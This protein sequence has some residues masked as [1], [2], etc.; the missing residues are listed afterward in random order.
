[1][2]TVD[3]EIVS[4]DLDIRAVRSLL[5]PPL[6]PPRRRQ[7]LH[8]AIPGARRTAPCGRCGGGWLASWRSRGTRPSVLARQQN[9]R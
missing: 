1:V 7:T 6:A 4:H 2:G 8:H 9:H 3:T 5:T